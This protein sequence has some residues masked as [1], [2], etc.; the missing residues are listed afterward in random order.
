MAVETK[1]D[2]AMERFYEELKS[3]SMGAL[4]ARGGPTARQQQT[5]APYP[6]RLWRWQDV[7]P[8]A[9]RALDMVNTGPNA[10]RRVVTLNNPEAGFSGATHSLTCG[11]QCVQP[12]DISPSHRHVAAAI[13]FIIRGEGTM[14]I[15][16]GEPVPMAP[17]DLVPTP[18]LY[19]HGHISQGAG[20]M[21]WM[22]SLDAPL[23]GLLRVGMAQEP[24]GDEIE[25]FTHPVGD[26]YARYGTAHL[27]PLWQQEVTPVSP[28][29]SFPWAQTEQALHELAKVDASPFDDVAMEY[30]HPLRGGP[31]LPTI[32]CRI[33]MLRPN[34]HT[35]AHRHSSS[36]VYHVFRGR[37]AS[38]IDGVRVEW[39]Q[40]DFLALPPYAWHEHLNASGT[41]EA[42]LFS[43]SD[44]AVLQPLNLY[45]EDGYSENGGHQPV[46]GSYTE[47]YGDRN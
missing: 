16:N 25:P 1:T 2:D 29:L 21:M 32:S 34:I 6:P 33:Q 44:A 27:R 4:W 40:G 39:E 36:Q 42:I 19:W 35:Q 26:N 17:G 38:I 9:Y 15:V 45:F 24:Y 11:L 28:L 14:T 7:E 30:T 37:G 13:R 41:E 23:V 18:S 3:K 5:G 20:P 47:R 12:G 10:E 22:D 43:T 46:T 31:V 8:M